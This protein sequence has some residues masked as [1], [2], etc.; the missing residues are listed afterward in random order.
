MAAAGDGL[1]G[2]LG[3]REWSQAN[4]RV[5][6]LRAELARV[7][8]PAARSALD[9]K[10]KATKETIARIEARW[11]DDADGSDGAEPA[12]PG[13]SA[14]DPAGESSEIDDLLAELLADDADTE[15]KHDHTEAEPLSSPDVEVEVDVAV[16]VEVEV[17]EPIDV[18]LPRPEVLEEAI[19]TARS[20]I[21]DAAGR[22]H[23]R[24]LVEVAATG[25]SGG[26]VE[27]DDA[28]HRDASGRWAERSPGVSSDKEDEPTNQPGTALKAAVAFALAVVVGTALVAWWSSRG[29]DE[30]I[31]APVD[32]PALGA[33]QDADELEAILNIFGFGELE[34]VRDGSVLRIS[35]T[36]ADVDELRVVRETARALDGDV[37]V[38]TNGI[39]LAQL[40]SGVSESSSSGAERVESTLQRDLDRL[41]ATTPVTFAPGGRVLG[42]LDRRILN[43][44][45]AL[46]RAT[47]TANVT[48]VGLADDVDL[49]A[50]RAKAAHA[51]LADQGVGEELLTAEPG[52][53]PTGSEGPGVIRL[54]VT[55]EGAGS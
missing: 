31:E 9:A 24:S 55:L 15:P 11:R 32:V 39:Q 3:D 29:A 16:E 42:E 25:R 7:E 53:A 41:L 30:G 8:D 19:T 1:V 14:S 2:D 5:A 46:I 13:G 43:A 6:Q 12:S 52:A 33:A 40:P 50:A 49:A 4:V 17:D 38:D 36:V 48:V 21:F 54:V 26:S 37:E 18:S 28:G 27:A 22:R 23:S 45:A 35:G 44:V 47:P 20:R 10:L 51:Y 34:V